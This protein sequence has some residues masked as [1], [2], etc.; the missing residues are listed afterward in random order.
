MS[1][2]ADDM[3]APRP[4]AAQ[5]CDEE[6]PVISPGLFL[7]IDLQ[8]KLCCIEND[9]DCIKDKLNSFVDDIFVSNL[10]IVLS[11]LDVIDEC[12]EGT[13]SIIDGLRDV[14]D[15]TASVADQLTSSCDAAV[16]VIEGASTI[17][18][19]TTLFLENISECCSI[20]DGTTKE[21]VS[22][23]EIIDETTKETL[24]VVEDVLACCS[25]VDEATKETV[26]FAEII[27]ETTKE[28]LSV[29][30]DVLACCSIVDE[31]T[32]ETVSFAEIIDE[33]TKETLSVV[34]DVLAC[35]SIV[36]EATKET[37][38]F[39]ED[40][41]IQTTDI[42]SVVD[43]IDDCCEL[44]ND[45]TLETRSVVDDIRLCCD[46]TLSVSEDIS[47]KTT[48]IRSVVDDI[49]DCCDKTLSLVEDFNFETNEIISLLDSVIDQ[50]IEICQKLGNV[51]LINQD[52]V[53]PNGFDLVLSGPYT[54]AEDID[55]NN[56]IPGDNIAIDVQVS[57]VIINLNNHIVDG[58]DV[59]DC[60]F[61]IFGQTNVT[62]EN[63]TI[64]NAAG[65]AICVDGSTEIF[66]R[67]L[68]ILSNDSD[69]AILIENT[70]CVY[71]ENVVVIDTNGTGIRL[72][73][74][75]QGFFN[76]V[77]TVICDIAPTGAGIEIE[78]STDLT[79]ENCFSV[80]QTI[81]FDSLNNMNLTFLNC[82]AKNNTGSGFYYHDIG[83]NSDNH[84]FN[85]C[86]ALKNGDA[87]FEINYIN[88]AFK[89]SC[90]QGNDIGFEF[91]SSAS[92]AL[93]RE[94][95]SI[96]NRVGS[97]IDASS[98][99]I[100]FYDSNIETNTEVNIVNNSTTSDFVSTQTVQH[101]FSSSV[102]QT[103]DQRTLDASFTISNPGTYVIT[104]DI[105]YIDSGY[106]INV[107]SDDVILDLG[108]HT[109]DCSNTGDGAIR[110]S[111]ANNVIVR[112]GNVRNSV[113]TGIEFDTVKLGELLD[114]NL[115]NVDTANTPGILIIDCEDIT[116]NNVTSEINNGG[117][118]YDVRTSS[119]VK[120]EKSKGSSSSGSIF[121]FLTS[122]FLNV[123]NSVACA[124]EGIPSVDVGF[125]FDG[126]ANVNVAGSAAVNVSG[127]FSVA[128]SANLLFDG[129]VVFDS[130]DFGF[131]ADASVSN[132]T[133]NHCTTFNGT[134]SGFLVESTSTIF[135][136]CC[137][138]GHGSIGFEFTADAVDAILDA[139][140]A[141]ENDIGIFIDPLATNVNYYGGYS[142][143]N[144]TTDIVNTSLSSVMSNFET[145]QH[146]GSSGVVQTWTQSNFAAP[147]VI[148]VPGT[149][150]L[151]E[152]VIY[153]GV[154][155]PAITVTVPNVIIDLG[156]QTIDCVSSGLQ[157][158]FVD[159]A[160]KVVIRHGCINN[161]IDEC[162]LIDSSSN[163]VIK[164][165]IVGGSVTPAT[166]AIQVINSQDISIFDT[167]LMVSNSSPVLVSDTNNHV[168][169]CN[170]M[171]YS[172]AIVFDF[173]DTVE[174]KLCNVVAA[175]PSGVIS[176]SSGFMFSECS[177]GTVIDCCAL[178]TANG[179]LI[180][181]SSN[182]LFVNCFTK[183]TA[184]F[185][186][187]CTGIGTANEFKS[188]VASISTSGSGFSTANAATTYIT[189]TATNTF[190]NG[191]DILNG[192]TGT[193]LFDCCA[194]TCLGDGFN[195][196]GAG[197]VLPRV[198]VRGCKASRCTGDGFNSGSTVT[199]LL[200]SSC[201][202]NGNT[203]NGFNLS[204]STE[205]LYRDC[206]AHDNVLCGFNI[207]ATSTD[208]QLIDTVSHHNAGGNYCDL[209]VGTVIVDIE[210]VSECV[211][212]VKDTVIDIASEIDELRSI[213]DDID[214]CC[215]TTLALAGIID[216]TTMETRS[217]VDDIDDCVEMI[218]LTVNENASCLDDI[219]GDI[220][221][222]IVANDLCGPPITIIEQADIPITINTSGFY[223][224][225]GNITLGAAGAGITINAS[226]VDL[227]LC[228]TTIDGA[229]VADSIGI[230]VGAVSNITIHD[231]KIE[232]TD[233]EAIIV[234]SGASNVVI[235]NVEIENS[236]NE[237]AIRMDTVEKVT[238]QDI[239]TINCPSV[240]IFLQKCSEV[241]FTRVKCRDYNG[242]VV[243][244]PNFPG[245]IYVPSIV[246]AT[247]ND[248]IVENVV[249]G[250]FVNPSS[251]GPV[252]GTEDS[253]VFLMNCIAREI[254]EIAA[255]DITTGFLMGGRQVEYCKCI[256]ENISTTGT[257]TAQGF[258]IGDSNQTLRNCSARNCGDY[259]FRVFQGISTKFVDCISSSN[260]RNGFFLEDLLGANPTASNI[261][262]TNCIAQLHETVSV[263]TS[264][265]YT[266]VSNVV[267]KNCISQNSFLAGFQSAGASNLVFENCQAI[268]ALF[269]MS[270]VDGDNVVI[271]N[272][273]AAENDQGLVIGD[274]VSNVTL[275]NNTIENNT[276]LNKSIDPA[277]SL[278]AIDTEIIQHHT[279]GG[280]VVGLISNTNTTYT[281]TQSG[282]YMLT[283]DINISGG[284]T[285]AIDIDSDD[286]VLDLGGFTISGTGAGTR[287]A[288]NVSGH[289][290]V[291]IRNGR[292][293]AMDD[294]SVTMTD[295]INIFIKD[296]RIDATDSVSRV[297]NVTDSQSVIINSVVID[298]G[299]ETVIWIES[300]GIGITTSEVEVSNCLL[301]GD[302]G[303]TDL[304]L[305]T[306]GGGI[307]LFD[308]VNVNIHDCVMIQTFQGVSATRSMG[309][310]LN[311]GISISG[312]KI[313]EPTR[314]GIIILSAEPG[315]V[316]ITDCEVYKAP[317]VG[318][319]IGN[320]LENAMIKRCCA[321]ACASGFR[322]DGLYVSSI[323]C[324]SI[325]HSL[326]GFVLATGCYVQ[327]CSAV[328]NG[329]IG[330][331]GFELSGI[332]NVAKDCTASG[333]EIGFRLVG[334]NN[335]LDG[336]TAINSATGVSLNLGAEPVAIRNC[337]Y[338]FNSVDLAELNPNPAYAPTAV[339]PAAF[340]EMQRVTSDLQSGRCL[341]EIADALNVFSVG[342]TGP[343]FSA[344]G[345]CYRT[346]L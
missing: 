215:D 95:L 178:E 272:C 274:D 219:K 241:C 207:A 340:S 29:V 328:A 158:I 193:I 46:E 40:I 13:F 168:F 255:N 201:V 237:P 137:V 242:N 91:G 179:F 34:E 62:I 65:S 167:N 10:D 18:E 69:N 194:N 142:Q 225:V 72:D 209:G 70:S 287:S 102:T 182:M 312:C 7:P 320:D 338:D 330:N 315:G 104:E 51:T 275:E 259:G 288:I 44:V 226:D 53:D 227:N 252:A 149:Y 243:A 165:L 54:L 268:D 152:N 283:E 224:I 83:D 32:K 212:S 176:T 19:Q 292:I 254:S 331:I 174:L 157:G 266:E 296:I 87:G 238:L 270:F 12:C 124:I 141:L 279:V 319:R 130:L 125:M 25:I 26:S 42:R 172:S 180:D 82:I 128:A 80:G 16:S 264:G 269:G 271:K 321:N 120:I 1:L 50:N 81:G 233:D 63:G 284:T 115:L 85:S 342:I 276:T 290:N 131:S 14:I 309:S 300:T 234:A 15:D 236:I 31:A 123:V 93:L 213:A 222:I 119:N 59:I 239:K 231:G 335:L 37:V 109:I 313:F 265:F 154:G 100:H 293:I 135:K 111:T 101:M 110:V 229:S 36:D 202:A 48:D 280:K 56:V 88:A 49:D 57:N 341:H 132:W 281:I 43:K 218:K 160:S 310:V 169:L 253:H 28:T 211:M 74:V 205:I 343:T 146:L 198:L 52:D 304:G 308:V 67:N 117:S 145:I 314:N 189:C 55:L 250:G 86:L 333:N 244:G 106:A 5:F 161:S 181:N 199:G 164:D 162:I 107:A 41:S 230:S 256:A 322:L 248:C 129:A 68:T 263:T 75:S 223:A 166:T 216:N 96:R 249:S 2:C 325:N 39:A 295:S 297:I 232:N 47:M 27:D 317:V 133:C 298:N 127:G 126:C 318:Y 17:L 251:P 291:T 3:R 240:H 235:R 278:N 203:G 305:S 246:N 8:N 302:N 78:N 163:V 260:G 289:S 76:N 196:S 71:V 177:Q 208:T 114:I 90:A 134:G 294:P 23:S 108:G 84:A 4:T 307:N 156:G 339:P 220:G 245:A 336:C 311:T 173:I 150:I 184:A 262:L 151:T 113:G 316:L 105:V 273:L 92:D 61:N 334:L 261:I 258:L 327:S 217:V 11:K 332:V 155:A 79:F 148:T 306:L 30:E 73:N 204:T 136:N 277:V 191:F 200:F 344:T 247:F 159:T 228:N 99:N 286:V 324:H 345:N 21:T 45:T 116:I 267:Y 221:S 303:F 9:V 190:A 185:G 140:I 186:F 66:L 197:G 89:G 6:F 112:H 329:I 206:E 64:A 98:N 346:G 144:T 143:F 103:I 24:S 122:K 58:G 97:S 282:T 301:R 20:V 326:S 147:Q 192:A 285:L 195:F 138:I 257:D 139:C 170:V 35:C 118:S 60:I 187:G 183:K 94:I 121:S 323:D 38:S 188:C 214:V 22:F 77:K 153:T 171:G 33:T 299:P 175:V 210:T 337:V